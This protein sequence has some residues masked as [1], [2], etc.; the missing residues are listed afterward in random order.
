MASPTAVARVRDLAYAALA[1]VPKAA[2][3]VIALNVIVLIG[4]FDYVTGTEVR[5]FPLYFVPLAL[6]G[7]RVSRRAAVAMAVAATAAW[8]VAN[9][10]GGR[11]FVHAYV[12]PINVV[13]QL[14]AFLSIGL[15]VA[16][17]Q[18]RLRLERELNRVDALTG[19]PNRRAFVERAGI[20]FGLAR[21]ARRPITLAYLDL[22]HFK[23]VNDRR[24]HGAGDRALVRTAEAM[25]SACRSTDLLARLGGDEF[26]VLL[27]DTGADSALI[28]LERVR[29]AIAASMRAAGDPCTASI[30][31]AA[32]GRAPSTIDTAIHDADEVM[33]RAKLAGKDR[34][35]VE[36]LDAPPTGTMAIAPPLDDG[37]A[38]EGSEG[39]D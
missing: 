7:W 27:P 9:Y 5:V 33:Y 34:V 1:P 31:A 15:L 29:G 26:A 14:V 18:R 12:W 32:Y 21:R 20:L 35:H 4:A 8:T 39:S 38:G 22:D 3:V 25:R 24:G 2:V 37:G 17:L 28:A 10:L 11:H 16:E 30:G 23:Q 6:A 13:T 36:R 19:L